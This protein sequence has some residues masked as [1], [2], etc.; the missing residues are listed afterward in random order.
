MTRTVADDI[1]LQFEMKRVERVYQ[2]P[3]ESFLGLL[4]SLRD[5]RI[6]LVTARQE[7]GAGFMALTEARLTGRAG[8]ALVTRG[9]G[10]A[11]AFISV[12][13]AYQDATP[14]VLG[15][16]LIPRADR[17]R[18]T[19]Q[20]FDIHAWF[21]STAKAVMVLDNAGSAA[22]RVARAFEIAESGRPGPV[23]IGLPEDM[24]VLPS[25]DAR[26]LAR[27]QVT[28]TFAAPDA[29]V[30]GADVL[31]SAKKPVF[32]VGGDLW[33]N[34][35]ADLLRQ[36]AETHAIPVVSDYRS[37]DAFAHSSEAWVG[38]LG[39][40]KGE[41]A[42][43]AYRD[44]DAICYLGITRK[45]VLSDGFTLGDDGSKVIV[46]NP[47]PDLFDHAGTL[48]HKVTATPLAWLKSFT[49]TDAAEQDERRSRL[50]ELRAQYIEWSTPQP[51][52]TNELTTENIF[53]V[54]Q[55]ALPEDSVVTVGAGNYMAGVLRYLH[56]E[57]PRS[58]VGPRNGA[59]GLGVPG[60]VAASLVHPD[61]QAVV[62]AGDG[63]FGMNGQEL[64]TVAAYGGHPLVFVFDNSGYGTIQSHQERH[65]PGRP[66]GT[67]LSNPDYVQLAA[68][69][70][71]A[72]H[73][74]ERLDQLEG[75]VR[76]A[77]TNKTSTLLHL[78]LP[79]L[80][81]GTHLGDGTGGDPR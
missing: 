34:E 77:I 57:T 73:R 39:F 2:V 16:G 37:H 35:G 64:A 25:E 5:S 21:G 67:Y 46:V 36:V 53:S 61:R 54:L 78:V 30:G 28:P 38:S 10:A 22:E 1:A 48:H 81:A 9:P 6:Q 75:V 18:E 50:N 68:A 79:K 32:V 70:G 71:M 7:G 60:A 17:E 69:H 20:E 56:H 40:I 11:N 80:C 74:V 76:D 31:L 49:L 62:F 29:V 4:N 58:F 12:H 63:C 51:E 55:S 52:D 14:L 23:V 65:F 66:S 47:D 33:D 26:P 15:V 44:A 43:A 42:L 27:Q 13:T 19:F 72:G 8:V 24:L 41:A 45:D 59:M 3:G